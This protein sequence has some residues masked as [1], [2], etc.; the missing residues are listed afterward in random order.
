MNT[1]QTIQ[2]DPEDALDVILKQELCWQAPPDLTSNLLRLVSSAT[3]SAAQV[4]VS[5]SSPRP[6]TWYTFAVMI[7]TSITVGLSLALAWQIY[8]VVGA[9][10]GLVELWHQIQTI[11]SSSLEWLYNKLPAAH[12]V[13]SFIGS[14]YTQTSWLLNWI[15]VA[16]VLWLVLDTSSSRTERQH[17]Q[18]T[19]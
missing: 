1:N 5:L 11:I 8:G 18:Q 13:V 9:E 16:L 17:Q 7:L 19:L 2:R 15:L 10:L 14:A 4:P 3:T 6:R 12:Y